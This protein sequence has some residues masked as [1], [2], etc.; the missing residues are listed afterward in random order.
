MKRAL[1]SA[2]VIGGTVAAVAAGTVPAIATPS[3]DG[4]PAGNG[5][6]VQPFTC[7]GLG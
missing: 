6:T 3:Y 7:D 1:R 2:L 5:M 4:N